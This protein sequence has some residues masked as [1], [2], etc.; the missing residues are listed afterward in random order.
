M[1][2]ETHSHAITNPPHAEA[3]LNDA[4]FQ[5]GQR[6]TWVS[7]GVN[8][9]LTAMQMTVGFVAHSQSLIADAMHTLSDIV[10]DAF[11]LFANR[12]GAEAPDADHPYGHGRFE[13]AASLVLGLLLAGTGVGILIAAA[14]R[15]QNIG[16]AP[17][18]GVAAMW[19]ALFTL[20]A[21]EGLFRY[22]LTTAERL[23]SPMLVANAWHARADALSSLVVAAGIGGA[24]IGFNFADAVAAIVV[25]AMIV[26][27]GLKFGWEAIRELI[28]TGL[29]TEEVA[30][31]RHTIETTPGVLG[32]HELRTRRMA[33][34]VLVDAHVQV[35]P[36]I[37][38]SEGHR[39][40]ETAR[41]QVLDNHPEVLDVLVHV[42]A[43]NDLLGNATIQLP[44]R[45]VLLAHLREMLDADPP[46]FER[47]TLHYLGTRVE[48]DVFLP[49]GFAD[50]ARLASIQDSVTTALHDDPWF[51]A[52]RLHQ[53]IAPR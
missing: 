33:H 16:S 47:T 2:R 5:E 17:P 32:L 3:A 37:S 31:I 50:E 34:Q 44:G 46:E 15:L 7:V 40:A 53:S 22:M 13:T 29:S 49:P 39:I 8:I 14:G 38:V 24:L 30:A 4:R 6:I 10:S 45:A 23:R 43:E 27:A 28:D 9:V 36:R 19:A 35:N 48:A 20:A 42:D 11:V 21:K 41:Q 1:S 26:R 51:I 25:G 18:V 12:K 52:I